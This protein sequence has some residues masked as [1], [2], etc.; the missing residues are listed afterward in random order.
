MTKEI[1]YNEAAT[2]K[3]IWKFYKDTKDA[4]NDYRTNILTRIKNEKRLPPEFEFKSPKDVRN[5]YEKDLKEL[6]YAAMFGLISAIEAA[7]RIDHKLRSDEEKDD[8]ISRSLKK[9]SQKKKGGDWTK[10]G[11]DILKTWIRSLSISEECKKAVGDLLNILPLRDWLAHGRCGEKKF[12]QKFDPETILIVA[13]RL[14]ENLPNNNFYG[15][16]YLST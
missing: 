4:L 2:L 3:N 11:D 6:R 15:R 14:I 8:E 1:S 13:E 5:Q 7:F 10:F 12:S 9:L 16:K